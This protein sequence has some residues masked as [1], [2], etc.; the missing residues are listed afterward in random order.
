MGEETKA[1]VL[2]LLGPITCETVDTLIANYHENT[3]AIVTTVENYY[4]L[5]RR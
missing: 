5:H 2:P 4:H 3:T 1:W